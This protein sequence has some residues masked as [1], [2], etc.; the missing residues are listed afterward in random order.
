MHPAVMPEHRRL[1][2]VV[3]QEMASARFRIFSLMIEEY[4]TDVIERV[5]RSFARLLRK[6]DDLEHLCIEV[7]NAATTSYQC[8]ELWKARWLK[9]LSL[10]LSGLRMEEVDEFDEF[11]EPGGVGGGGELVAHPHTAERDD[12]LD[13]DEDNLDASG[14]EQ[15]N[16]E[17]FF[18]ALHSLQT[19]RLDC[20]AP[21]TPTIRPDSMPS[22]RAVGLLGSTLEVQWAMLPTLV[23]P[24]SD[25]SY[26]PIDSL[27]WDLKYYPFADTRSGTVFRL[28]CH[29]L[30]RAGTLR[31]VML[32]RSAYGTE[33][34]PWVREFGKAVPGIEH[35]VIDPDGIMSFETWLELL[36]AYP[37]LITLNPTNNGI[38]HP[39]L[40]PFSSNFASLALSRASGG[41]AGHHGHSYLGMSGTSYSS[42]AGY[43]GLG[44]QVPQEL[45]NMRAELGLEVDPDLG[46]AGV[47]MELGVGGMAV[48]NSEDKR[49]EGMLYQLSTVCPQLR[50]VDA[51]IR[52]DVRPSSRP[53]SSSSSSTAGPHEGAPA[54]IELTELDQAAEARKAK[55][56]E[57]GYVWRKRDMSRPCERDCCRL[58]PPYV[59]ERT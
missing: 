31:Q 13:E 29:H 6:C 33:S 21:R 28:F 57:M 23:S 59:R 10:D 58:R 22:L 49:E 52:E 1:A 8:A 5:L 47:G 27:Q 38:H 14:A 26:R 24:L 46:E 34:F 4:R 54:A 55:V 43:G 42:Y 18:L 56:R 17:Q 40:K 12:G 36:S 41:P 39:F 30:A 11:T 48:D 32:V 9:L 45:P 35:F 25:G 50:H 37:C 19:L 16:I 20:Y 44:V 7:E 2:P 3:A 15:P 53:S 51:W